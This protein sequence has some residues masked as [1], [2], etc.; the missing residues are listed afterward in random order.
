MSSMSET[1]RARAEAGTET[2]SAGA[3]AAERLGDDLTADARW[4]H[5]PSKGV[6]PRVTKVS[7]RLTRFQ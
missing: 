1:G 2:E 7:L 6:K 3:V 5:G 4:R